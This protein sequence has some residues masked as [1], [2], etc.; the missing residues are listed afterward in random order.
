[1]V[2]KII[3]LIVLMIVSVWIMSDNVK[4]NPNRVNILSNLGLWIL[5]LYI[6]LIIGL[7]I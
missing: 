2:Y 4:V 5:G 6:G 7:L 1:M 3:V